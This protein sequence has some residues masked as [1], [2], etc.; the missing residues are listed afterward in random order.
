M[1]RD[2]ENKMLNFPL[3]SS[4]TGMRELF[5]TDTLQIEECY[6]WKMY[7]VSSDH[8][9]MNDQ[10]CLGKERKIRPFCFLVVVPLIW[11]KLLAHIKSKTFGF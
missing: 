11:G 10:Y 1:C 2:K 5:E 8:K 3:S 7:K 4:K 9:C 6:N